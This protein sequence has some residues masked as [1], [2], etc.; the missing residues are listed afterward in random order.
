MPRHPRPPAPSTRPGSPT[1]T[2]APSWSG[3][4][5]RLGYEE[6]TPDPA[7]GDP[8]DARGPRRA[9]PGRHRHRQ[10]GR[11]R[12]AAAAAAADRAGTAAARAGAGAHPRAGDAG[13][14]GRPPLRPRPR[15]PRAAGLRRP[16]RSGASCKVLERGVDVVVATPGPRARPRSSGA[17]CGSTRSR[18]SCSTRPTRC[19]TWASPRTSRRS[20][21]AAPTERQTVLFSATM[22]PRIDGMA[23]RHL[24]DPV[25]VA[26]RPRAGAPPARRRKVRQTAYV[27]ARPHKA[28]A[29]GRVLDVEAPAATHRLLPHPRGGRQPHRDA[30]RPRLPRRG[31]AR[32]HEPGAARPRHGPAA[33]RHRRAARRHRRRR[34]RARPRPAHPRRQLQ[35]AGRARVLRPPHR[36]G[37]PRG[38]R[39]RRHHAGR[40]ARAPHALGDRAHHRPADHDRAGADASRTCAAARLDQTAAALR[41]ALDGG[42]PRRASRGRGRRRSPTSTTCAT[43]A[44]AAVRLLHEASGPVDDEEIPE[45]SRRA[46]RPRAATAPSG[47]AATAAAGRAGARPPGRRDAPA[48]RGRTRPAS[49][50]ATGEPMTRLFVGAGRNAGMRPQDLVGA[51]A[52]ETR[53]SGKD[54]GAIEILERF[55]LVEVPEAAADEVVAALRGTRDQ[56]GTPTVRRERADAPSGRQRPADLVQPGLPRHLP[57]DRAAAG[58]RRQRRARA[59]RRRQPHASAARRSCRRATRRSR[60]PDAPGRGGVGRARR[61]GS[62]P[63]GGIDVFVPG[64]EQ[65]AVARGAGPLR[66]GRR[67][68]SWSARREALRVLAD[69]ALAHADARRARRARAGDPRRHRRRRLP[70]RVRRAA[71]PRARGLHEARGRPRR[72]GLPGARRDRRRLGRPAG[73]AVGAGAP[74]RRRAPDRA[75][76]GRSRRSWCA[77]TSTATRSASTCCRD[78]G[79]VL[80][81]VAAQQGRSAVDAR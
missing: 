6:P 67:A 3:R 29:L 42:R 4:S 60:E 73:A 2:C 15:R 66:R 32:R 5:P 48:S 39:G 17:A 10:D 33:Q 26:D 9:R 1:S 24:R 46:D 47:A 72:R 19:S 11:L 45:P 59:A 8:A 55:S 50:R 58:G 40:A 54:V 62:A 71:R 36:P 35:R 28:A 65:L 14:G 31:A 18:P 68:A 7:R 37:R 22:P 56:G 44:L 79:E 52:G 23:R 75:R 57:A 64:R 61:C 81:A 16:A 43:V 78:D 53:L 30:E 69:K 13:V 51:I 76:G 38:A 21:S 74:R 34:P 80:A 49:H 25:R 12:A 77:S 70:R 20:S 27:V 63:S 41:E